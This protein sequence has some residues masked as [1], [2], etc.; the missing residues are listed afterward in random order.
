MVDESKL[1]AEDLALHYEFLEGWWFGE[2]GTS[3]DGDPDLT[4]E[5][6]EANERRVTEL[7]AEAEAHVRRFGLTRARTAEEIYGGP[8]PC[9]QSTEVAECWHFD[10]P[11]VVRRGDAVARPGRPAPT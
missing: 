9:L 6:F 1:D 11:L 7:D 10:P 8:L 4:P 5:E 2:H 3:A